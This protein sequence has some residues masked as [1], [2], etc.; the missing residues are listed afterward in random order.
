MTDF[1]EGL[2]ENNKQAIE[3]MLNLISKDDLGFI[4]DHFTLGSNI[5]GNII[6]KINQAFKIAGY[7]HLNWENCFE[8]FSN[9]R[10]GFN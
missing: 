7:H 3:K 10:I 4:E 9:E 5:P 6:F 8:D 2:P 1:L